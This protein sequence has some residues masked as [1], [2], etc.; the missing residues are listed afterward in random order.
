MM[1]TGSKSLSRR[2]FLKV[3]GIAGAGICRVRRHSRD[4]GRLR[5]RTDDGD[6]LCLGHDD[7]SNHLDRCI[8]LVDSPGKLDL[9]QRFCGSR[10]VGQDRGGHPVD[11]DRWE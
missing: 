10:Q 3:A 7:R 8:Q 4:S 11:R 1:E 2:E 5:R 6:D 9:G